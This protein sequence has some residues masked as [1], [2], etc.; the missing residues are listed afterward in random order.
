MSFIGLTR[1]QL[2]A[3]LKNQTYFDIDPNTG[4]KIFNEEALL[5]KG[6]EVL[7]M[8]QLTV[9]LSS[10]MCMTHTDGTGTLSREQVRAIYDMALPLLTQSQRDNL[11]NWMDTCDPKTVSSYTY[12]QLQWLHLIITKDWKTLPASSSS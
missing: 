3:L 8:L 5:Q 7:L 4:S 1:E 11:G 9:T 6:G 12:Q 2:G 10:C